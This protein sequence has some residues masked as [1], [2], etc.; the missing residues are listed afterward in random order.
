MIRLSWPSVTDT[1]WCPFRPVAPAES[2]VQRGSVTPTV[3]S[4][5]LEQSSS[6]CRLAHYKGKARHGVAWRRGACCMPKGSAAAG[7]RGWLAVQANHGDT[8]HRTLRLACD[9]GAVHPPEAH[10]IVCI[11]HR[12]LRRAQ[13]SGSHRCRAWWAAGRSKAR[14]VQARGM[15]LLRRAP[16]IQKHAFQTSPA[17]CLLP[18]LQTDPLYKPNRSANAVQTEPKLLSA[19][20]G[21]APGAPT[22]CQPT[23]TQCHCSPAQ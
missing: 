5:E 10:A 23:Q 13:H 9:Q 21:A 22:R 4:A 14:A 19:V 3:R 6:S 18:A 2:A 17:A 12:H 15:R 11:K 16:C 7:A 1:A 8:A 20:P